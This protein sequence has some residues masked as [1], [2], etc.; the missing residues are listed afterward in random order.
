LV[1]EDQAYLAS[2]FLQFVAQGKDI[3]PFFCSWHNIDGYSQCGYFLGHE[4]IKELKLSGMGIS[5]HR[6]PLDSARVFL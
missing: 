6:K 2:E 3:R 5:V 4:V 1:D